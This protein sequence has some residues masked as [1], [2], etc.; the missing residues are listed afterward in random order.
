MTRGPNTSKRDGAT[1][2]AG[3]GQR[4][5][6]GRAWV[7]R[8]RFKTLLWTVAIVAATTAAI[9]LTSVSWVPVVGAACA[10]MVMSVNKAHARMA[11]PICWNC[12]HDVSKEPMS[13]YG[14][15]CPGCGSLNAPGGGGGPGA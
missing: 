3:L 7:S 10:A 13:G 15:A 14:R 12:G 11:R 5:G 8:L 9:A 6:A 1:G 4:L 2:V